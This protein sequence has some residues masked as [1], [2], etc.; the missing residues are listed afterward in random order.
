MFGFS[1]HLVLG[2]KDGITWDCAQT[3]ER[4]AK[5]M[6]QKLTLKSLS[7]MFAIG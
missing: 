6:R 7:V 2:S 3:R 4:Q 5:L 1:Y